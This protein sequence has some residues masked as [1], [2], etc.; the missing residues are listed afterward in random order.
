MP[1]SLW[2]L[3]FLE[4]YFPQEGRLWNKYLWCGPAVPCPSVLLWIFYLPGP[5]AQ[6]KHILVSQW[7]L[8]QSTLGCI[9][10]K[11]FLLGRGPF[12]SGVVLRAQLGVQ[13]QP[14][15]CPLCNI[16]MCQY[17][18]ISSSLLLSNASQVASQKTLGSGGKKTAVY[19]ILFEWWC[20][21]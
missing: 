20:G 11:C 12:L 4:M 16:T 13:V 15:P 17:K 6:P 21:I 10:F 1:A 19:F 7:P 9:A 18:S 5:E 2:C 14:W 8:G 3:H